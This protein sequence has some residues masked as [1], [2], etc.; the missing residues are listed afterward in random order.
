MKIF[1]IIGVSQSGKT[2]TIEA[3]IAELRRRG[4]SVGSIKEIHYEQF[5]IDTEGSNTVRHRKAG[6]QLV[7]ARGYYETDILYPSKL[8]V[9]EILAHYDFD[10]AAL[11]G[12]SDIP[13]PTIICAHSEQ[14]VEERLSQQCFAVSG[15]IADKQ[16]RVCGLPAI[17]VMQDAVAL[18]DLI[19]QK[20]AA[21]R[22]EAAYC[23]HSA[24]YIKVAD[25]AAGRLLQRLFGD[26]DE[27][28]LRRIGK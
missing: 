7:T 18:T 4:Y 13:V 1:S 2:T 15:R 24:Q 14:E 5:A 20:A 12:V 6:S 16:Y 19:E 17:S 10:Y 28:V 9:D 11:E 25:G 23:Y 26:A 8:P 27:I 22:P 21:Y 3:I